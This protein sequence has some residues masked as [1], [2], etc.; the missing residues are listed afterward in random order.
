M[1]VFIRKPETDI[2]EKIN[3][4]DKSSGV[5][6][7]AMLRAETP[8]E[9]FNL[10]NAGRKNFIINGAMEV[11]QRGTSFTNIGGGGVPGYNADRWNATRYASN[12]NDITR[13]DASNLDGF[14]Y[15]ARSA[16]SGGD[17]TTTARF[18]HQ[19]L[20]TVDTCKLAGNFVTFS[21]YARAGAGFNGGQIN[22]TL[23]YHTEVGKEERMYYNNFMTATGQVGNNAYHSDIRDDSWTRFTNTMYIPSNAQ[24]VSVCIY[25][26]QGLP[27][28]V[29]ADYFE[30]TGCQ[31]EIGKFATPFEHRTYGEELALCERFYQKSYDKDAYVTGA[32]SLSSVGSVDHYGTSDATNVL[33]QVYFRTQMRDAPTV[34]TY[35][36]NESNGGNA[37][38][39]R[40]YIVSNSGTASYNTTTN[41]IGSTGFR[42]YV[43]RNGGGWTAHRLIFQWQ[44]VAEL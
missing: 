36:P 19:V 3:E 23:R 16:R 17:T 32:T 9:Q 28:A 8:E 31:L 20:E 6:G 30:V 35:N 7:E 11:W 39:G 10:I 29:S 34:T 41:N 24:Q 33:A 27:T 21:F 1:T 37:Y 22:S 5:A 40:A 26:E 2:R 43:P 25:T 4:L 38:A 44:A 42:S 15:C 13:E 14:R 18:F 12:Y